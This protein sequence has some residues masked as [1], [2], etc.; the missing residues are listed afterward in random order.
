MNSDDESGVMKIVVG[1]GNP[2][3]KYVR[4]RHN[5]GFAVVDKLVRRWGL[6]QGRKAF[7]GMVFDGRVAAPPGETSSPRRVMLLEPHTYM[8][9][10]GQAV[11]AVT[12]F[13]KVACSDVLIVLDDLALPS[14]R[15]RIRPGGSAGGHKGLADVQDVLGATEIARLRVGIGQP[16]E[17]MD[18]VDFVLSRFSEDEGKTIQRAVALAADAVEDWLF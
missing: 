14:G 11:K 9:R 15:L 4:T 7:G 8:N 18:A 12:A 1:L 6:G 5:V 2:G 10:S 17:F 13:Y 3:R 16:P